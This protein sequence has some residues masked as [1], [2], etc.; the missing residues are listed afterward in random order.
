MS[1]SFQAGIRLRRVRHVDSQ[2]ELSAR[3]VALGYVFVVLVTLT[4]LEA[5]NELFGAGGP[6]ALYQT[7][8][9]DLVITVAAALVLARS[10]YEPVARRAWL[11][12]GLAMMC[13]SIGSISWSLVY[14]ARSVV[15]YPTFADVLW[16]LWYPLVA[17]GITLLIKVHLPRFELNRW[18]DGIAVTLLV[19][20]AGFAI[21]IQP[22]ADRTSEGLLATIVS[23]SYPVLDVLLMG[24]ILGVYGLLGW[25]SGRMWTLVGLG[26]LATAAAD[27]TFAI[28][29]ARGVP[30]GGRYDFVWTLGALLIAWAAWVRLP[31][32]IVKR[33]AVTGLRAVALLLVAQAVAAGIQIYALFGT[34]ARSE[35]IITLVVLLVTSVQIVLSRPRADPATSQRSAE[36]GSGDVTTELG[37][38]VGTVPTALPVRG[39][40]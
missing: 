3:P 15:P 20:A 6:S 1:R 17:V 12:F 22:V 23:F 28:Q 2:A 18:M 26:L 36:A 38:E 27:A 39:E 16:L 11:A 25:R 9:H 30:D 13:W 4:L 19:L 31:A 8:F 29:S 40:P 14:D 24:A 32:P 35:R 21:V 37:P 10:A 7:W 33:D 5:V 34:L